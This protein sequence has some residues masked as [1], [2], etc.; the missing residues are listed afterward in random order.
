MENNPETSTV[1]KK[2]FLKLSA[3]QGDLKEVKKTGRNTYQNYDY[4]KADD[5]IRALSPLLTKH[6]VLMLP[7][8]ILDYSKTEF[9]NSK[10]GLSYNTELNIQWA[11]VDCESGETWTTVIPGWGQDTGEKG[12]YKA[13]TGSHKYAINLIFKNGASD[14]PEEGESLGTAQ[15][16]Q[17]QQSN[18][19]VRNPAPTTSTVS[20]P[21]PLRQTAPAPQQ[22][23]PVPT[24]GE[25][26]A[27]GS[28]TPKEFEI[29][30]VLDKVEFKEADKTWWAT[31][32]DRRIWT[33]ESVSGELL[34]RE[35]G[36]ELW[37][38]VKSG[39]KANV[40]KLLGMDFPPPSEEDNKAL[41]PEPDDIKF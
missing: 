22:K 4:M 19:P 28:L 39:T 11:F 27:T 23:T 6:K 31:V 10:Q 5:L 21:T 17:Q 36:K 2:L 34:T 1:P 41:E 24:A 14:D 35:E 16:P 33:K 29:V 40:F 7:Q 20:S 13:L 15:R 26:P 38:K 9:T 18:G 37:F 32:G 12:G 25:P 30:A 3:I 8:A